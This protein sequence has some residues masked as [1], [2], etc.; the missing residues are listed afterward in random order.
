MSEPVFAKSN[1]YEEEEDDDNDEYVEDDWTLKSP[2]PSLQR[3][4]SRR[5]MQNE[6]CL[7]PS[8]AGAGAGAGQT[9]GLTE[10]PSPTSVTMVRS[11]S[12]NGNSNHKIRS[13]K[14]PCLYVSKYDDDDESISVR[15]LRESIRCEGPSY[16]KNDIV[17]AIHREEYQLAQQFAIRDENLGEEAIAC[18]AM[19]EYSEAITCLHQALS[20]ATNN[21]NERDIVDSVLLYSILALVYYDMGQGLRARA[22]FEEALQHCSCR[23]DH[24][25]WQYA[26]IQFNLAFIYWKQNDTA[27]ALPLLE[28]SLLLQQSVQLRYPAQKRR[29]QT[30][31]Q[32]LTSWQKASS[33]TSLQPKPTTDAPN[34]DGIHSPHW[35]TLEFLL[36]P[37]PL[38]S[39][40]SKCTL[41][42]SYILSNCIIHDEQVNDMYQ[43]SIFQ[44]NTTTT[45]HKN[46]I[47]SNDK[48][49]VS[50]KSLEDLTQ[51]L[52]TPSNIHPSRVYLCIGLVHLHC[53]HITLAQKSFQKSIGLA[54]DATGDDNDGNIQDTYL[55]SLS[56]LWLGLSYLTSDEDNNSDSMMRKQEL[57][58]LALE[59]CSNSLNLRRAKW[60]Y[61][62]NLA[63]TALYHVG[64]C[65]LC[66]G[67][68]VAA[69]KAMEEIMEVNPD[70]VQVLVTLG[71]TQYY[72]HNYADAIC[73]FEKALTLERKNG[74]KGSLALD[75]LAF[76]MAIQTLPEHVNNKNDNGWRDRMSTYQEML[77]MT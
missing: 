16:S 43:R 42:I 67:G 76:C 14:Y 54:N 9:K 56:F 28:E 72:D 51:L 63:L 12:S 73:T 37:G 57:A 68:Y 38:Y 18:Y 20:A 13:I 58:Y 74:G 40:T 62:H 41:Q 31:Q 75:N 45:K 69:R 21:P 59:A 15:R 2:A 35:K 23:N 26:T 30:T 55:K 34:Y 29:I 77:S 17:K 71:C 53:K 64:L 47:K 61:T 33:I 66:L 4:G 50:T 65:H 1:S 22:T 6:N 70:E 3:I 10:M 44:K 32:L 19:Q 48:D 7:V 60:G 27:K 8:G 49:W 46:K 25:L 52:E 39:S 11:T 36:P 5:D 24:H